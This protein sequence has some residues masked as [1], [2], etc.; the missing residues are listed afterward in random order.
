MFVTALSCT[1]QPGKRSV[2]GTI[3]LG[4][5]HERTFS[6]ETLLGENLKVIELQDTSKEYSFIEISK[7][8][9]WKDRIYISDWK[10][11]RIIIFGQDGQPVSVLNRRGANRTEYLVLKMEQSGLYGD[12]SEK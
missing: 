1:N 4:N 8:V 9:C 10:T 7:L 5:L 12:D 2:I 3:D 11:R 6:W